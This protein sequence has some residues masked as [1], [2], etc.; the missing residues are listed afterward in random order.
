M[1]FDKEF[2][3]P[4]FAGMTIDGLEYGDSGLRRNLSLN[5]SPFLKT[6]S[7]NLCAHSDPDESQDLPIFLKMDVIPAKAGTSFF[8]RIISESQNL[9]KG[10]ILINMW[11]L[12]I[13]SID[14]LIY[15]CR[16]EI[17]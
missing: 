3:V 13:K 1:K 7:A 5:D 11:V 16:E 9:I 12:F 17:V 4:A 8:C 2:E 6:S 10:S 15:R 14:N